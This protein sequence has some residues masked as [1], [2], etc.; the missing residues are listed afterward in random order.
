MYFLFYIFYRGA[1]TLYNLLFFLNII[2]THRFS[3]PVVSV[4]NISIG[5]TGKTPF[6]QYLSKL[7]IHHNIKPV[8]IS[9]GYKKKGR[10]T[11]VV[12]NGTKKLN[13]SPSICG[14][15][16]FM[17]ACVLNNVPIVV[18]NKKT[19]GIAFAIEKFNPQVVI[20]DDSFQSKYIQK[21]LEIVLFNTLDTTQ[22][23]KIFP[24]G[25]LRENVFSLCRADLVVF[26]KHNLRSIKK[27]ALDI[28]LPIIQKNKTPYIYSAINS[29]L[30]QFFSG[31]STPY[32]WGE[33]V[34]VKNISKEQK[35]FSFCGI[36]DPDSFLQITRLYEKNIVKH[37]S[38]HDHYNYQKKEFHFLETLK[39]LYSQHH[40]TGILT[41]YK[42]FIK[43]QNLSS[44]FLMW[45]NRKNLSFFVLDIEI[46]VDDEVLVLEY[47]K[48]L[49]P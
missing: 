11:C 45:A 35:L 36:G 48:N 27:P 30:I 33:G 4:G 38:F 7:L 13:V 31:N 6:V 40:I 37:T 2:K 12:H 15:E 39:A 21:D 42:D 8:I 24:F 28:V 47:I 44:D 43:I 5:G 3:V 10:G 23:L 25:K 34:R 32:C 29:S 18:D 19:R 1:L 17:L 22:D 49:I 20:L 14:D 16:P 41:T 26:T 46:K 9:R